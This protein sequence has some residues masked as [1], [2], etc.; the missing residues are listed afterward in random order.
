V[1]EMQSNEQL[2]LSARQRPDGVR[3][4]DFVKK[5]LSHAVDP[6]AKHRVHS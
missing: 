2:C 3:I 1:H 5:C 6:P 4:P